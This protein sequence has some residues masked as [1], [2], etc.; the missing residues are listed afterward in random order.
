MTKELSQEEW[1][2]YY[3]KVYAYFYRR[4]STRE[5]ALDL[6]SMT[7]TDFFLKDN[8]IDNPNAYLWGIAKRKLAW[9]LREKYK[10]PEYSFETL[11]ETEEA[12]EYDNH[13][14]DKLERLKKCIQEQLKPIDKEIVEICLLCDFSGKRAAEELG[15]SYD[16]V[17]QRLSRSV[18]KLR[19]KC[20]QA[21]QALPKL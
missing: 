1:N 6:T 15:L 18:S 19:Q 4:V 3:D 10:T 13:Y 11:P 14:L 20:R 7:L 2:Q 5:D 8:H 21:W 12:P 16:N 9:F 17:R